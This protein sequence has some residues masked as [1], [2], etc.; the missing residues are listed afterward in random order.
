MSIDF[1]S[2]LPEGSKE[3]MLRERIKQLASEGLANQIAKGEAE[4]LGNTEQIEQYTN[5]IETIAAVIQATETQLSE[6]VAS[7]TTT[8]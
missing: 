4:L 7:Q 1:T 2:Y 8:V 5:N 3:T 6:F